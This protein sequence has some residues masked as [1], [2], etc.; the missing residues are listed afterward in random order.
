MSS[1]F[2][3]CAR[4]TIVPRGTALHFFRLILRFAHFAPS[5]RTGAAMPP[6]P[7]CGATDSRAAL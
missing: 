7:M 4:K 5:R 2:L 6:L 1:P 3:I